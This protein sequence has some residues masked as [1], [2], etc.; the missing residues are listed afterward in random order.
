MIRCVKIN[1]HCKYVA[2]YKIGKMDCIAMKPMK[3]FDGRKKG[4][5]NI[6]LWFNLLVLRPT[7]WYNITKDCK[8]KAI[9]SMKLLSR[10]MAM[11]IF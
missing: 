5:A 3:P 2:R 8:L 10:H 4:I 9:A 6:G 1:K 7:L 11:S